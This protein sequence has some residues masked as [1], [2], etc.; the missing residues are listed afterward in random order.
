VPNKSS[1]SDKYITRA[2][3]GRKENSF[4]K[5][6]NLEATALQLQ[7]FSGFDYVFFLFMLFLCVLIGMYFGFV[8]KK[9]ASAES[10]YLMGGRKMSVFPI[11]LSLIA[12]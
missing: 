6:E 12:R 11:S 8:K 9:E 10:E 4:D 2:V 5:M 3:K 1:R 7:R